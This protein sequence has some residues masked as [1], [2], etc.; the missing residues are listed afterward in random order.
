MLLKGE[1]S[2]YQGQI[3][4]THMHIWDTANGYEW[5]PHLADGVLNY[6]FFMPDYLEMGQHQPISQMVFVEC[7]GFPQNPV[8]ETKWV[9]E[10]ADRYGGP[11]GIAAFAKLDSP[12][13]ENILKGHSQYPNLRSIRMPLNSVAGHFGADRDDYMRDK[14]W[15]RG[16]ALLS[17]YSLPF[18]M[19]IYD[20]QIPDACEVARKFDDIPIILQ[21]LG[22]PVHSDLDYLHAW[23]N[24]LSQLAQFSNVFLKISCI[25]WIFQ[26]NDE[27]TILPFIR[28]AVRLFGVDRCMVGSNCPPDRVFIP[29]DEIFHIIKKAL[30]GYSEI[31]QQKIFY[32]NARRIYRL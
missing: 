14:A 31:D 11:Q 20:T 30:T 5:L 19:Q 1:N 27:N 13:I 22:W 24:R 18:E 9:Q 2:L 6:N 21:H 32:G 12:D 10:Q 3:I 17:K 7:G 16:Y 15:Q 29:F 23:K 8:L 28:E 25:G 4:D 26:K